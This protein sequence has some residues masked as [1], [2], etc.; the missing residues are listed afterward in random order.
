MTLSLAPPP[1]I[2]SYE[3]VS[4]ALKALNT[5]AAAKGYAII[6]RRSNSWKGKIRRINLKCNKNREKN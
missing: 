4:D 1:T 5:F 3:S 2:G 6:K